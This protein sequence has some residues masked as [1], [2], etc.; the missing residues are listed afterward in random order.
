M[1]EQPASAEVVNLI[2]TIQRKMVPSFNYGIPQ[3]ELS[4][5]TNSLVL[6]ELA[7]VEM[8]MLYLVWSD[9]FFHQVSF[10]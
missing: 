8:F 5:L 7:V 9:K 10:R 6:E 4:E 3:F 2:G 1:S